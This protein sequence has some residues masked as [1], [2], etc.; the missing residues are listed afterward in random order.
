MNGSSM[1]YFLKAWHTLLC[2]TVSNTFLE[3]GGCDP[4]RLVS[5]GGSLSELLEREKVVCH[6]KP[7]RSEACLVSGLVGVQRGL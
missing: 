4:Q 5:L 3:V 2:S 1:P 7:G 6:E